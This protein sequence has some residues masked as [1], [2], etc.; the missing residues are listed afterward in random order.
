MPGFASHQVLAAG[1]N[2][3]K[4]QFEPLKFHIIKK[5]KTSYFS[6]GFFHW[7]RSMK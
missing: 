4:L 2:L 1:S 5:L 6:K 3:Y 7:V